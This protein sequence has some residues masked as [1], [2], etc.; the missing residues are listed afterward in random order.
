M[1]LPAQGEQELLDNSPSQLL[2]RLVSAASA[3]LPKDS[4]D[5]L[6]KAYQFASDHHKAQKRKSG[7][8]YIIH[9]LNVA[10]ILTELKV[11]LASLVAGIL[12]DTIE[13]TDATLET[14][15][16]RFGTEVGQLVDGLTKIGKIEFRSN[17]EKLAENFRKMIL[18]M[19]KDLR[20]ILVKLADRLHNMRTISSLARPKGNR[21]AQ[22][23]LDIYAPL[24]GRLG[25]YGIKSELEDLCLRQ[26]KQDVYQQ[27]KSKVAA[28]KTER[29]TYIT[30]VKTILETEL[31]KYHFEN[32]RVY[33]RPKHFYSIY[34]KMFDRQ[35]DFE[36]I[37]DLFGFRIIV[38][39]IKD[40]YEAL[41]VI[42]AMWKPMPGRFKDYI[43]I[44]KANMYQSLHTTVI[45]PNGEPAEIQ[46]RTGEMHTVCEFGVAAHWSYK[47]KSEKQQ[48]SNLKKFTWLRRIVEWQQELTDPSE[49]MEAV[50]VDLFDEE[51][52]VFTPKGDVISL[53]TKATALDFA[54]A[55]HTDV[56]FK[57]VGAKVNARIVPLKKELR[58]GDIVE[59]LTSAH[60]KPTKDWLNFVVTSKA[61]S[62]IRSYLRSAQRESSK[63]IGKELLEQALDRQSRSLEKIV[64]SGQ[65][66]AF[67]KAA[68]ESQLEDL[69][70]SIGYGK[71]DPD[72]LIAKVFP[73]PVQKTLNN[74]LPQVH[75]VP[76][77]EKKARSTILVSGYD[78]VMVHFGKCCN[79]LPGE[80]IV[81][82]ITRGKGVTIHRE[83]CGKALD[84]DPQRRI[85]VTWTAGAQAEG[86]H[87]AYLRVLTRDQPGVLAEVTSMISQVGANVL[88]A[89]I[90]VDHNL[91]GVCD[92]ELNI[93][94][95]G[96]L[97]TLIVKIESIPQVMRVERKSLFRSKTKRK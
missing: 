65:I 74:S 51:I 9:P 23:T 4:L 39:T 12:H 50:K 29:Q 47:E 32:V 21:I 43:A 40:C 41:G 73:K 60:Q 42:H 33:G 17:Q 94:S 8:P 20:V 38:P 92:F 81:G 80:S 57:T 59:I 69:L 67:I 75:E 44:P 86:R 45:R 83:G 61:R 93:A 63:K 25:I 7:E 10:L 28:K 37:H 19:A 89:E 71:T 49:F 68:R 84:L 52:F 34:K 35:L 90:R 97:E 79:P 70:I 88:K 18:A 15:E 56:G 22:E 66:E 46:I 36:D 6:E 78:N 26:L 5:V 91:M 13:D 64:K 16:E 54:F 76:A 53:S 30:E 1:S 95:L 96:Q 14:L 2:V 31:K 27:I 3:Y 72:D 24:A 85:E 62:K 11:D 58:S 48:G 77:L 55:V 82:F 87:T